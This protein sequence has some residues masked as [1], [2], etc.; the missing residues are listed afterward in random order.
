M[1]TQDDIK[2]FSEDDIKA[3]KTAD[4]IVERAAKGTT[5]FRLI[6]AGQEMQLVRAFVV[7]RELAAEAAAI[8]KAAQA[9]GLESMSLGEP[10]KPET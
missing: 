7:M 9:R 10:R 6:L 4:E 1:L 8:A 5:A 3:L 2:A